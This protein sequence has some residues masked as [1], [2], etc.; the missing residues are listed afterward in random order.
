MATLRSC[1]LSFRR[2]VAEKPE[3][4]SV[5]IFQPR[6]QLAA[7]AASV[8][9]FAVYFTFLRTNNNVNDD[10]ETLIAQIET[11]ELVAYLE[12]S[13]ITT[14]ELIAG[15]DLAEMDFEGFESRMPFLTT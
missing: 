9:L 5:W 14:E 11:E 3:K 4:E 2:R 7:V 10:V 15:V 12:Y 1:L 8:M 13:D 6:Y